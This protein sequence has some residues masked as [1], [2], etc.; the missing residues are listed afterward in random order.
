[1]DAYLLRLLEIYY[2]DLDEPK[3]PFEIWIEGVEDVLMNSHKIINP[4]TEQ[5]LE[6]EL[7][8]WH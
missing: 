2:S 5:E 6:L 3:V 4:T 7:S 1:M 8:K